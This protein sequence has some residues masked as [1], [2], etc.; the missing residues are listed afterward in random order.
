VIVAVILLSCARLLLLRGGTRKQAELEQAFRLGVIAGRA[1]VP[2][3]AEPDPEAVL[4]HE[5]ERQR[6]RQAPR[7]GLQ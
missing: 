1:S 5:V 6:A 4:L 7:A 3:Q 2:E